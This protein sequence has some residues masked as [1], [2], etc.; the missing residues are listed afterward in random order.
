MM[1][2]H[3][4]ETSDQELAVVPAT[5]VQKSDKSSSSDGKRKAVKRNSANSGAVGDISAKASKVTGGKDKSMEQKKPDDE[6]WNFCRFLYHKIR[7]I[8]EGENKEGMLLEIQQVVDHNRRFRLSLSEVGLVFDQLQIAE[9][10]S[11]DE[12]PISELLRETFIEMLS[13][14]Y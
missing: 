8:P 6:D 14:P 5:P 2:V 13:C 9:V 10:S 4:Q 12:P 11:S 1:D 3:S 7:A